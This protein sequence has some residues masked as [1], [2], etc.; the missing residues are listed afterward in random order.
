MLSEMPIA[1][2]ADLPARAIIVTSC[3]SK[4]FPLAKGL[5]RS[6]LESTD[7]PPMFKHHTT[8]S[9]KYREEAEGIPGGPDRGFEVSFGVMDGGLE[10]EEVH[11]FESR[12]CIVIKPVMKMFVSRPPYEQPHDHMVGFVER[13]RLPEIFPG[14]E[15]YMWMDADTWVQD[16]AAVDGYLRRA[17]A[18]FF[19][20]VA[21]V[22]RHVAFNEQHKQITAGWSLGNYV[23]YFG[24]DTAV[25]LSKMPMLNN[26][27]F[28]AHVDDTFWKTWTSAM[29]FA[30]SRNGYKP[31]FGVDQIALNFAVYTNPAV[32]LYPMPLTSNWM[33]T[34]AMPVQREGMGSTLCEPLW[35]HNPIG[36][37]HLLEN[38]KW[39]RV[40]VQKVNVLT[41]KTTTGDS[42]HLEYHWIKPN[43][44]TYAS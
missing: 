41:G 28:A 33:V 21:E 15:V 43:K 40:G 5:V 30:L 7:W 14:H 17:A 12:G 19:P 37:I 26:G 3:D 42:M 20:I 1:L 9:I 23:K 24:E 11:W 38:T 34:H 44:R 16:I 36:I 2:K 18:G 27:V 13:Y 39:N 32:R 29:R 35:P 22:D 10:P 25:S 8:F 6:L 4:Y 31:E